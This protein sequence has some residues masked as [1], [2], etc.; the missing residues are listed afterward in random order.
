MP[1]ERAVCETTQRGLAHNFAAKRKS[2]AARENKHSLREL[3][4][5]LLRHGQDASSRKQ[6]DISGIRCRDMLA[7]C[8]FCC[9]AKRTS[10]EDLQ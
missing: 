4:L 9:E 7:H 5:N 10:T 1:G 8:E 2:F 6:A 3:G